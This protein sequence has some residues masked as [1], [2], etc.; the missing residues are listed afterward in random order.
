MN[1]L[2]IRVLRGVLVLAFLA[3]VVVMRGLLSKATTLQSDLAEVI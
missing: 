2:T 1:N 3:M